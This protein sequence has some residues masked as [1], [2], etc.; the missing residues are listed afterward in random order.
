MVKFI[1]VYHRLRNPLCL[2]FPLSS[3]RD[4][5]Q[6]FA[7]ICKVGTVNAIV[8]IDTVLTVPVKSVLGS[9]IKH[10]RVESFKMIFLI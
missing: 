7:L 2:R 4:S 6:A 8:S 10:I 9:S 5:S 3:H 1:L